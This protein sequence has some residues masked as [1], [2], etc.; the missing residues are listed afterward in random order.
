MSFQLNNN[1]K[2]ISS[3]RVFNLCKT[4]W[5]W[6][7]TFSSS[8]SSNEILSA[9]SERNKSLVWP[10]DR[11]LSFHCSFHPCMHQVHRQTLQ[12]QCHNVQ[13]LFFLQGCSNL[14]EL[15]TCNKPVS[16]LILYLMADKS[17]VLLW[18][19]DGVGGGGWGRRRDLDVIHD[20]L[21][22]SLWLRFFFLGRRL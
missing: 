16:Q 21:L 14:P 19:R 11:F 3:R 4:S 8:S 9:K 20:C 12:I 17:K 7:W 15:E 13:F 18:C 10:V 22:Y 6:M 2:R 5:G 1:N